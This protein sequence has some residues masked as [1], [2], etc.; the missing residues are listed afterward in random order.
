MPKRIRSH[1]EWLLTQLADATA[2]A[3]YLN[4]ARKESQSALL[5]ALRNVAEA[6]KMATVAHRA[7]VNRESLYRTLSR[8][9]NPR[10]ETYNSVLNALGI[11]YEFRPKSTGVRVAISE[12]SISITTLDATVASSLSTTN[13]VTVT[14]TFGEPAAFLCDSFTN[15]AVTLPDPELLPAEG[16]LPYYGAVIPTPSPNTQFLAP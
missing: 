6:R 3:N 16:T 7:G 5:K 10:L 13:T 1:R 12:P 8:D 4:E 2:A 14:G 11:E 15:Q 9:G